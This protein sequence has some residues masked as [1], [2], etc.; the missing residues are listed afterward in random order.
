[1]LFPIILPKYRNTGANIITWYENGKIILKRAMLL[2]LALV[3]LIPT[4][5][6]I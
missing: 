2:N 4:N 1:L 5:R 6:I 3:M